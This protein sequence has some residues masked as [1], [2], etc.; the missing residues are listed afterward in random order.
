MKKTYQFGHTVVE[1]H[2][3]EKMPVPENM[4][5]FETSAGEVQK[6]CELDFSENL[7]EVI[8]RFREENVVEKEITRKNN[9]I[10]VSG[11]KE[12]R[13]LN[14]EGADYAYAVYI[15]ETRE[16]TYVWVSR[17]ILGMLQFDA[18]FVS[19]L[20]LEKVVLRDQAIILHS[21]Y[22]LKDGKAVLFSAPS[23]TGKSTQADL[24]ET[25]RNTRTIN[26]DKSLLIREKDGWYAHGW[27]ICGS[28]EICHNETFPIQAVVMLKQ[29]ENNSVRKL[30]LFE[31]IKK[32]MPQITINMW[33]MEFQIQAMDLIQ[34]LAEEVP[35]YELECDIS[36][37]A[38]ICLENVL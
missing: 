9:K 20:G 15:E 3:P 17:D 27:P 32:L 26:G 31:S 12:C 36:E 7:E 35:V 11:E 19:L 6:I 1:L 28:S 14:F 4:K 10:L 16:H 24:W 5:L 2:I 29:A 30:G 13:I 33:N 38:V 25:Y 23:G 21:A 8:Q 37:A 34:Q 22:M 18:V